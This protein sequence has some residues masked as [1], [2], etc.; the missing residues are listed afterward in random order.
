[1]VSCYT[2]RAIERACIKC[3]KS[4]AQ[5]VSKDST[6][7]IDSLVKKI[8]QVKIDADESTAVFIAQCDSSNNVLLLLLD[9]AKGKNVR[10]PVID[11]VK[12]NNTQYVKVRC[13]VDSFAVAITY[14]EKHKSTFKA[15]QDSI[16]VIQPEY[17]DKPL[18]W[19]SQFKVD[20]GGYAFAIIAATVLFYV[21]K[22]IL[23]I[24]LKTQLPI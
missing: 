20:F 2:P 24:Y 3:G 19:W 10:I 18:S 16:T 14:F 22:I 9:S 5:A 13:V 12:V 4:T 17:R 23:K 21:V 11:T 15:K 6:S 1:M 7:V 8:E